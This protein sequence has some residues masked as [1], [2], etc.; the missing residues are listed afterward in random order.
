MKCE[1][2]IGVKTI[3]GSISQDILAQIVDIIQSDFALQKQVH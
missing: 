2:I 3:I 1:V